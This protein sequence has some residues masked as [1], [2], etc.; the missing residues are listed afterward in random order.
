MGLEKSAPQKAL[1]ASAM[2]AFL[3]AVMTRGDFTT[4]APF[5]FSADARRRKIPILMGLGQDAKLFF[6]KYPLDKRFRF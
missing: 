5:V 2:N 1:C 4:T 3:C 6:R